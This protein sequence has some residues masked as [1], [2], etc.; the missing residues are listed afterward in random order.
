M[1][2]II[3]LD[4]SIPVRALLFVSS[5]LLYC[6]ARPIIEYST[7]PGAS[8]F[9]LLFQEGVT[10]IACMIARY[11]VVDSNRPG[12]IATVLYRSIYVMLQHRKFIYNGIGR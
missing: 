1:I 11:C 9:L 5:V 12:L 8:S 2:I 7:W 6:L 3:L 4:Q 10:Y